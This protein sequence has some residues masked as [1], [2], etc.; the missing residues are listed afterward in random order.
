MNIAKRKTVIFIV[1]F[2]IKTPSEFLWILDPKAYSFD[3]N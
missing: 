2:T 3:W 1:C